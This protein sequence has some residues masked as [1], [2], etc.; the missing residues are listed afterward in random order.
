MKE[1]LPLPLLAWL[2]NGYE[3][4]SVVKRDEG[5]NGLCDKSDTFLRCNRFVKGPAFCPSGPEGQFQVHEHPI[6]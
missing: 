1:T 4:P 6:L 2:P 3:K 5:S